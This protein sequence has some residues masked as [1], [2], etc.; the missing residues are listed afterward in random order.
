MLWDLMTERKQSS[1][2]C[3]WYVT[4]ALQR[5]HGIPPDQ[6]RDIRARLRNSFPLAADLAATQPNPRTHAEAAGN[7]A[8][9]SVTKNGRAIVN[10][11]EL[12][13]QIRALAAASAIP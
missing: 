3:A 10:V 11:Q 8:L 7:K 9:R 2:S 1:H 4:V 13:Q 12:K 5:I 6:L